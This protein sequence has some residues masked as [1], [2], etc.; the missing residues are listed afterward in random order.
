SQLF[1]RRMVHTE[2]FELSD[3]E[4]EFYN[5]LLE[6]LRDG[7]DMAAQQGNQGR[8][9]G[10]VMTIFQKIAASSFAAIRSTLRRR[11]LML[12]VQ[13]AIERD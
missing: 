1:T 5:S 2:G 8:A 7:Y 4:K 10:F 6:Y 3:R 9:L 12:T 13:E 11:L